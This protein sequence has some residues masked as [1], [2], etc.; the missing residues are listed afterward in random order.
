[1]CLHTFLAYIEEFHFCELL[2]QRL[3]SSGGGK[4]RRLYLNNRAKSFVHDNDNNFFIDGNRWQPLVADLDEFHCSLRVHLRNLNDN[5]KQ[6]TSFRTP[7]WLDEKKFY[8]KNFYRREYDVD[9][10]DIYEEIFYLETIPYQ[11]SNMKVT[12]AKVMTT[13][14]EQKILSPYRHVISLDCTRVSLQY[15]VKFMLECRLNIKEL[16]LSI[17][18]GDVN[19]K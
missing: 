10:H 14:N 6:L 5:E 18:H 12:S 3:S 15:N 17:Y 1:M 19:C 2:F 8:F 7:F 11:F 4:L 9:Y 16:N 13:T